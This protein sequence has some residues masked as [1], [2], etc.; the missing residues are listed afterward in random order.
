MDL[1]KTGRYI[2]GK[3]KDLGMTQKQL[4]EQL[5]MSDKSV[6]K[7]ERGVCLPDVSLYAELCGI[8]GISINEFIAGE[9]IPQESIAQKS[10]ENLIGVTADGRHRQKRLKAVICVL[11]AV[12]LVAVSVVGAMLFRANEPHN[13]IGP[14]DRDSVEMKT[15]QLL[16]GSDGAFIY[17]YVATDGFTSLKIYIS[18]YQSG[19]LVSKENIDLVYEDIGSPRNGTILIVPDFKNF[20][21]KLIAADVGAKLSTEIPILEDVPEREYYGRSASQISGETPIRYNEEQALVALIYDNDEMRVLDIQDLMDGKTA[22]LA[23]ND[24]V[25]FFSFEFRKE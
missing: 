12:T 17:D 23:Q 25:Y 13:S 21:I 5:G 11:L 15:A 10:E 18:K 8:L 16:S 7:W 2:A 14:I 3:R 22:S 19:E 20:K 9:D 6:S 4:A 24:Y 1:I